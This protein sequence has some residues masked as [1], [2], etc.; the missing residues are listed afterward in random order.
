MTEPVLEVRNF[1][2]MSQTSPQDPP[3]CLLPPDSAFVLPIQG[4]YTLEGDNQSGKSTL[5]KVLMGVLRPEG[6][7]APIIAING[8]FVSIDGIADARAAGLGAVFQDD[9]LIPSLTV[10]EQI[11]LIFASS[12]L[13]LLTDRHKRNSRTPA[14][15]LS[16][17]GQLLS[18]YGEG[19]SSI[20]AKYPGQL[21]GGALAIARLIKAQ[22]QTPLKVLFLDE[23]FSGVQKDVWPNLISILKDWGERQNV[24]MV[25]I[26]HSDEEI[27]RWQPVGRLRIANRSLDWL[28]RPAGSDCFRK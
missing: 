28:C 17:A 22:L 3:R 23:A 5:L 2:L 15:V 27:A 21:S 6:N 10:A 25:A 24:T 13:Q 4:V 9:P 8:S 19:Y 16:A 12:K 18:Q 20:L 11:V 7:A 26:T 14:Q 1:S